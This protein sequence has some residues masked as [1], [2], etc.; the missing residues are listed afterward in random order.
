LNITCGQRR[1]E[2]L[3]AEELVQYVNRVFDVLL[4]EPL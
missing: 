1:Q 4:L 2:G 3:F